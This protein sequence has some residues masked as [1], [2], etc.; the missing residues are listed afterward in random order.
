MTLMASWAVIPRLI[1]RKAA[2]MVALRE[3]PA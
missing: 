1:M 2:T 3:I